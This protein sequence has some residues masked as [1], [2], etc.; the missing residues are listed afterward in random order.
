MNVEQRNEALDEALESDFSG[1][2]VHE[3]TPMVIPEEKQLPA[4]VEE[5]RKELKNVLYNTSNKL[6][7]VLEYYVNNIENLSDINNGAIIKTSPVSDICS[8]AREIGLISDKL[9]KYTLPPATKV[10]KYTQN[11]TFIN[12]GNDKKDE[13]KTEP[14][15][16]AKLDEL[17]KSGAVK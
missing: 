4:D 17:I 6:N 13:E 10:D 1:V 3:T 5:Q 15:T 11:N 12:S 7:A 8:L 14:F 16:L 2:S 9:Y